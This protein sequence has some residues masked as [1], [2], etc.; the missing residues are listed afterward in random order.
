M[1]SQQFWAAVNAATDMFETHPI[2]GS[3]HEW[4]GGIWPEF[5]K[6]CIQ[7][8]QHQYIM[9]CAYIQ[10]KEESHVSFDDD[11]EKQR[12]KNLCISTGLHPRDFVTSAFDRHKN[13]CLESS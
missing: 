9:H 7:V 3:F 2:E 5:E 1:Q 10:W 12:L 11:L 8:A 13:A 4:L 6:M